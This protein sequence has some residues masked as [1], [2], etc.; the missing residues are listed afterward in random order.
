MNSLA[1]QL[2]QAPLISLSEI[3]KIVTSLI[4]GLPRD[5]RKVAL[6]ITVQT[7]NFPTP[8]ILADLNITNKYDL[9]GL[10]R[11][12]PLNDKE[13]KNV[14]NTIFLYRCPII[15][16]AIDNNESIEATIQH[17][18][19]YEMGHHMGID[20]RKFCNTMMEEGRVKK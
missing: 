7:E 9:L 11:G 14:E 20:S 5:L 15:R 13:S 19:F 10:Y 16:Y 18:F 17:V 3:N 12:I 1:P 2:S 4:R 6:S 8:L